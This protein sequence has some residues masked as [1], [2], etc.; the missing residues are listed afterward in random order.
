MKAN[1]G[2]GMIVALGNTVL[3]NTTVKR[4]LGGGFAMTDPRVVAMRSRIDAAVVK[5]R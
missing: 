3:V 4:P 1:V 5:N 2:K